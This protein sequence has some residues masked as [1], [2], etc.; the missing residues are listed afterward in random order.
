MDMTRQSFGRQTFFRRDL[1]FAFAG[2]GNHL[3]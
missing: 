2:L 1:R 3:I